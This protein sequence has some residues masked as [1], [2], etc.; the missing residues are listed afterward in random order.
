MYN[1]YT[2]IHYNNH[3][4]QWRWW[5]H[6]D[7][8]ACLAWLVEVYLES[9]TRIYPDNSVTPKLDYLVHLSQQMVLWVLRLI[10]CLCMIAVN[11]VGLV[12][13]DITG[14]CS[15]SL[16]MLKWKVLSL[17]VLK[18]FLYRLQST[19]VMLQSGCSPWTEYINVH[20]PRWWNY[21]RYEW[22]QLF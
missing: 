11:I 16:R 1:Y 4:I 22:V 10:L 2:F 13:S 20:I 8:P 19:L 7:D 9:F 21:L 14:A 5:V 17:I 15:L 18:M 3:T 6:P 12:H